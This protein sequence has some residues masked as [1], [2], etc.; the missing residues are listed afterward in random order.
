MEA[1]QA[2]QTKLAR[3]VLA[4]QL[5]PEF[6]EFSGGS[7]RAALV[8]AII[9]A[10]D[11]GLHDAAW[12]LSRASLRASRVRRGQLF[13]FPEGGQV[14]QGVEGALVQVGEELDEPVGEVTASI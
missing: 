6:R 11:D 13:R 5:P 8:D 7:L 9:H 10:S 2:A 12:A 4:N 3:K 1:Q 14:L